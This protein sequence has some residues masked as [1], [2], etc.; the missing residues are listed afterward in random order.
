MTGGVVIGGW[1]YVVAAYTL[2]GIAFLV[3]GATLIAKLRHERR[4][5]SADG[6]ES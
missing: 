5:A 1:E 2:T 4:R 3:Y 6:N